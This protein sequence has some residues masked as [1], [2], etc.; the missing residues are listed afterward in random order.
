MP[1]PLLSPTAKNDNAIPHNFPIASA[2]IKQLKPTKKL[3]FQYAQPFK[4]YVVAV[5]GAWWCVS[6]SEMV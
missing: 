6:R 5:F 2:P 1:A 4:V 3:S